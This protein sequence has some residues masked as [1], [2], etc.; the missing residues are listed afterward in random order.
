MADRDGGGEFFAGLV[1]GGLVG[2]AIALLMAPQSGVETRTQL[3][4]VS[5]ELKD[6][7]NETMAEAREKAD[8]I[9]A[10]ARRRGEDIVT[11]AR[12]RGEEIV[13]EARKRAEELQ[14][15]MP[16]GRKAAGKEGEV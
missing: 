10:D 14:A 12:R 1:I 6:R 16:A 9:V 8:A 13:G 3:R 5:L 4:D 11:E 15:S 7:A 2:A